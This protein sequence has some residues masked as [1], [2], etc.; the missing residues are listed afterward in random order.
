MV[1]SS[2]KYIYKGW[3]TEKMSH[4]MSD[5]QSRNNLNLLIVVGS[6]KRYIDMGLSLEELSHMLNTRV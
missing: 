5:A 4:K 1:R 6:D 2:V 3:I